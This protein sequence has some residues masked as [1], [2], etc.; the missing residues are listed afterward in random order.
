MYRSYPYYSPLYSRSCACFFLEILALYFSLP[1][2]V[3]RRRPLFGHPFSESLSVVLSC[4]RGPETVAARTS[5]ANAEQSSG[6]KV[7]QL[8]LACAQR[9]LAVQVQVAEGEGC[10]G[11][12][13]VA[14][15]F[16]IVQTDDGSGS[17]PLSGGNLSRKL[18]ELLLFVRG[19]AV[20]DAEVHLEGQAEG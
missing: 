1:Y 5:F 15:H 14:S 17:A 6:R 4:R 8:G 12:L 9:R 11:D 16:Q 10:V 13:V 18:E 3:I 7:V 19:R 2:L 20:V